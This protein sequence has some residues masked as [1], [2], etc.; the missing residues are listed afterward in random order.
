M[1]THRSMPGSVQEVKVR[2]VG[3]PPSPAKPHGPVSMPFHSVQ[4]ESPKRQPHLTDSGRNYLPPGLISGGRRPSDCRTSL[5]IYVKAI[6]ACQRNSIGGVKVPLRLRYGSILALMVPALLARFL[7]ICD[8][9][10]I[11]QRAMVGVPNGGPIGLKEPSGPWGRKDDIR[12]QGS[13]RNVAYTPKENSENE[14][15]NPLDKLRQ[16][17]YKRIGSDSLLE[18]SGGDALNEPG[19]PVAVA[20]QGKLGHYRD[21]ILV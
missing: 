13:V 10:R 1:H 21:S 5:T 8:M 3:S 4:D 11:S 18:R 6:F 17:S 16:C 2:K 15:H 9:H 14:L 7:H 12:C 20:P 19:R